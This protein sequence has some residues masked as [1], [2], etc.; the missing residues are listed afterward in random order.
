MAIIPTIL[1]YT[2]QGLILNSSIHA[3]IRAPLSRRKADIRN[4][5]RC[6]F[7]IITA[8]QIDTNGTRA[9]IDRIRERVG[10]TNTYISVDIDVLDLAF[11]PGRPLSFTWDIYP[12]CID[13]NC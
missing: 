9:I 3:G 8:R 4:D 12:N 2:S 1:T 5:I 10:D 11:A 6:G 7:E 13:F